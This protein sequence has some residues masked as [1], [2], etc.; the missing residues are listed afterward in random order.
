MH[1]YR[2]AVLALELGCVA[3]SWL[4]GVWAGLGSML[5]PLQ[6]DLVGDGFPGLLFVSPFVGLFT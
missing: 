2:P 3:L 1:P 4:L 6:Q 5:W